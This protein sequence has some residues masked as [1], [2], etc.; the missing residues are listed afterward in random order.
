MQRLCRRYAHIESV[1][2]HK[3]HADKI[4]IEGRPEDSV[5]R[6]DGEFGGTDI[7]EVD[8]CAARH[9]EVLEG[10]H[11]LLGLRYKGDDQLHFGGVASLGVEGPLQKGAIWLGYRQHLIAFRSVRTHPSEL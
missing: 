6:T 1:L 11:K 4:G 5:S 9:S 2:S 7:V 3:E 8:A 10:E